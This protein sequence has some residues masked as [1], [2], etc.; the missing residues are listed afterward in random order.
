MKPTTFTLELGCFSLALSLR[1]HTHKEQAVLQDHLHLVVPSF[2]SGLSSS[3]NLQKN[4]KSLIII[5]S[6]CFIIL[7]SLIISTIILFHPML[8]LLLLI[9]SKTVQKPK[10]TRFSSSNSITHSK[11]STNFRSIACPV[12]FIIIDIIS[13]IANSMMMPINI[14]SL[15]RLFAIVSSIRFT[16]LNKPG[17][18]ILPLV[19]I[20]SSCHSKYLHLS[21]LYKYKPIQKHQQ[22]TINLGQ[23]SNKNKKIKIFLQAIL[24]N[25]RTVSQDYHPAMMLPFLPAIHSHRAG[26]CCLMLMMMTTQ[27][28]SIS[29]YGNAATTLA[30]ALC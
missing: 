5:I 16:L 8:V 26:C 6:F 1:T 7:V 24:N 27:D 20:G 15:L 23:K 12:F 28:F 3:R 4:Y 21:G 18:I 29:F 2:C 19:Q 10:W 25:H 11:L 9:Q 14:F 30:V 22:S 17:I 13:S